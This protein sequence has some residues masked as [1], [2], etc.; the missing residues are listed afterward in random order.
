[1]FISYFLNRRYPLIWRQDKVFVS[2]SFILRTFYEKNDRKI[3]IK[4]CQKHKNEHICFIISY[5]TV[6]PYFA[7]RCESINGPFMLS[8]NHLIYILMKMSLH[9]ELLNSLLLS[10][11]CSNLRAPASELEIYTSPNGLMLYIV[12]Y[13]S[14]NCLPTLLQST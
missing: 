13:Y 6:A 11:F 9:E 7:Y 2:E 14:T 10:S 1:M 3:T 5:E 12:L 8:T 4:N